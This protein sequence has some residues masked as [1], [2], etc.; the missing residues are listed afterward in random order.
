MSSWTG[1]L[2]PIHGYDFKYTLFPPF[3]S[4]AE[5]RMEGVEIQKFPQF[6]LW[7]IEYVWAHKMTDIQEG[8]FNL[9]LL[10]QL[11]CRFV[12]ELYRPSYFIR[13]R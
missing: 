1:D 2:H 8:S 11:L 3:T 12:H 9:N 6:P 5:R 13:Y 4:R 10:P 7:I